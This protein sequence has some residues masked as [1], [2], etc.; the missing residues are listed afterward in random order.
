MKFQITFILADDSKDTLILTGD[1]IDEI[2]KRAA[3]EYG[4]R[5]AKDAWSKQIT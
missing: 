1:T 2:Q 3:E 5:G 4:H